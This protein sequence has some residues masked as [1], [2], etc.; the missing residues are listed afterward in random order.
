M[1]NYTEATQKP[2]GNT[3]KRVALAVAAVL[4]VVISTVMSVLALQ[5]P[6][7]AVN[8][9]TLASPADMKAG[10]VYYVDRLYSAGVF[11]YTGDADEKGTPRNSGDGIYIEK[12]HVLSYLTL[13]VIEDGV[14]GDTYLLTFSTSKSDG[15][16]F[17]R[18]ADHD[19]TEN[20]NGDNGQPIPVSAYLKVKPL[21][22]EPKKYFAETEAEYKKEDG[23]EGVEW[24][25]ITL[26]YYCGA[27]DDYKAIAAAEKRE[28]LKPALA[29]LPIAVLGLVLALRKPKPEAPEEAP[30]TAE[31]SDTDNIIEM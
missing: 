15:E 6:K 17:D 7:A 2:K 11:M 4:L 18:V 25:P 5:A 20:D 28:M 9:A 16:I 13:A 1:D 10:E 19:K 23:M 14:T 29:L 27:D 12:Q 30:T 8:L 22:G 21:K 31:S 26:E 24:L 3:A